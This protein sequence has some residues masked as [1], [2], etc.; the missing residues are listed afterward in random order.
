MESRDRY[1][2]KIISIG[3]KQK[4][5]IYIEAPEVDNPQ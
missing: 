4:L 2:D 5:Q 1:R 3:R